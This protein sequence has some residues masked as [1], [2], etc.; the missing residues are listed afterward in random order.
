MSATAG[1]HDAL[2][3]FPALEVYKFQ[4][5]WDIGSPNDKSEF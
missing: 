4:R 2:Y 3:R 5:R 1:G